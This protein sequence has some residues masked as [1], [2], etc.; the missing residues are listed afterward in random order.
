MIVDLDNT[1]ARWN[2]SIIKDDARKWIADALSMGFKICILSNNMKK[3]RIKDI[4]QELHV[5]CC[6][7]RGFRK[8]SKKAYVHALEVLN[9]PAEETVMIGDQI[10]TDINGAQKMGIQGILVDPIYHKE[11]LGTKLWRVRERVSGRHIVWQD[12]D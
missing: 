7:G 2:T 10:Y 3:G 8:P 9:A 11:A 12:S 4:A 6:G 5:S 1:I